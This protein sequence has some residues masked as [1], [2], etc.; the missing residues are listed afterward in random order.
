MSDFHTRPLAI[1]DLET[2]GL[3]HEEH[4]IIEIGKELV[5]VLKNIPNRIEQAH[6]VQKLAE[7]LTVS[8][9]DVWE[10]VKK[11]QINK[12]SGLRDE[13][14]T[15]N[16]KNTITRKELLQQHIIAYSGENSKYAKKA[17]KKLKNIEYDKK[18]LQ[19]LTSLAENIP[20]KERFQKIME[21]NSEINHVWSKL[22]FEAEIMMENNTWSFE[23]FDTY[24]NN[25]IA[26]ILEEDIKNLHNKI[27]ENENRGVSEKETNK[28]ITKIQLKLQQKHFS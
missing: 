16:N 20:K 18:S 3:N 23:I 11:V 12:N 15:I 7:K 27:R 13:N 26:A 6:W 4:E 24:L 2:T 28:L 21:F 14:V 1:T 10:E 17:L 8:Q 25:Y 5:S 19:L 9:E 22:A